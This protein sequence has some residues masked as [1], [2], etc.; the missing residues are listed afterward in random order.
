MSKLLTNVK[1][2]KNSRTKSLI[3]VLAVMHIK[4]LKLVVTI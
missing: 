3:N 4:I 1:E 2:S